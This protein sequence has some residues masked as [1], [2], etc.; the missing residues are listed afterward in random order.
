MLTKSLTRI[1]LAG[2]GLLLVFFL[3]IHLIGLF[4][5]VIDPI[6]F[7]LYASA[8]HSASWVIL[9]EFSLVAI[10]LIHI[11]LTFTKVLRNFQNRNTGNLVSRRK[12]FLA[13]FA[14]RSQ[15]IGGIV[16]LSFLLIHLR[17][18]R[19]P[20]PSDG[21]ELSV[22]QYIL[23]SPVNSSVYIFGS[24]ALFLHLFHG[25]ESSQRSLGLLTPLNSSLIR[26]FGR[27]LSVIISVGFVLVTALLSRSLTNS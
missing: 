9:C 2:S 14:A 10:A 16:L 24:L 5:A 21:S 18:L 25:I 23:S 20:R 15:P 7:E 1:F 8:L 17:Q 11:F 13:I 6:S 26:A 22:L 3:I 19:F 27:G 12:D 4:L